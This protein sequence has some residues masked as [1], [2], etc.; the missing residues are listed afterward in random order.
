[1]EVIRDGHNGLPKDFCSPKPIA[2]ALKYV[3]RDRKLA[4]QL[5][6]QA[7]RDALDRYSLERC[8]THQLEPTDLVVNGT[9]GRQLFRT[10]G[11]FCTQ[12]IHT[13][14]DESCGDQSRQ[15]RH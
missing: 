14:G 7:R 11:T 13:G 5:G 10:Q 6:S 15:N 12:K 8:L 4:K 3:L 9:I 2:E 1:M